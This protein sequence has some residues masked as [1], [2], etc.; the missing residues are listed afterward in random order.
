[1][2]ASANEGLFQLPLIETTSAFPWGVQVANLRHPK[3]GNTVPGM[4]PTKSGGILVSYVDDRVQ[5]ANLLIENAAASI[6]AL[7]PRKGASIH[8]LDFSIKNRFPSIS[9]LDSS[10]LFE[11]HH[12]ER[13]AVAHLENVERLCV[14]RHHTLLGENAISLSDYN[15][16]AFKLEPYQILVINLNDFPLNSS[17]ISKLSKVLDSSFDAGFYTIL[18]FNISKG[19]D[20]DRENEREHFLQHIREIFPEIELSHENRDRRL[21][22]KKHPSSIALQRLCSEFGLAIESPVME[23]EEVNDVVRYIQAREKDKDGESDFLSVPI[24]RTLN[25]R[26]ELSFNLG[27]MTGSF[28][29]FIIGMTGTG[30]SVFLDHIIMGVARKYGA[31]N[32]RLWLMDFKEGVEFQKY[33]KHPNCEKLLFSNHDA[34]TVKNVISEFHCLIRKRGTLFTKS[35]VG[36][37]SEY[38]KKHPATPLPYLVLII[39]EIQQLSSMPKGG[40]LIDLLT[41]VARRGRSQG[42]SMIM[43]TQTLAGSTHEMNLL[44]TQFKQRIAFMVD[45]NDCGRLFQFG[46]RAATSIGRYQ[47]VI[48]NDM[49]AAGMNI[50]CR[51]SPPPP[52][53]NP[54]VPNEHLLNELSSISTKRGQDQVIFPDVFEP[55]EEVHDDGGNVDQDSRRNDDTPDNSDT[56]TSKSK[57]TEGWF[58]DLE[59]ENSESVNS[60]STNGN[61]STNGAGPTMTMDGEPDIPDWCSDPR[62]QK[63]E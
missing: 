13:N 9:I 10:K 2:N 31:T 18:C 7:L 54:Q 16:Q 11:T 21:H 23:S 26:S 51:V 47:C 20:E 62:K 22:I 30:K 53:T 14:E 25:G 52:T 46:N 24:G 61:E 28:F 34:K 3:I 60:V 5:E 59:T 37:I 17:A 58:D 49:G 57:S 29:A 56:D 35:G 48:N 36:N 27:D 40:E 55:A 63:I 15:E 6:L 50:I 1:M 38:N 19:F 12:F 44:L 41:D 33:K 32:V 42:L 39:D 8:V 43:A 4:L 45:E